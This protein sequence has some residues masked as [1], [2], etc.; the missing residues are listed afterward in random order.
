MRYYQANTDLVSMQT[1]YLSEPVGGGAS[2]LL[3]W[4]LQWRALKI[5]LI[6]LGL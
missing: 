1:F 6:S 2:T 3:Y 5:S 4:G